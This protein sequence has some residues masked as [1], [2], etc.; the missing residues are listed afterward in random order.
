[1]TVEKMG[2]PVLCMWFEGTE[3]KRGEFPEAS[4]VPVIYTSD[5]AK[6]FDELVK[7]IDAI[8]PL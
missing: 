7:A 3:V 5:L 2:E 4:L 6:E 8:G 1:M